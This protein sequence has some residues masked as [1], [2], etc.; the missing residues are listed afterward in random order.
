M[1]TAK[2]CAFFS[3]FKKPYMLEEHEGKYNLRVLLPNYTSATTAKRLGKNYLKESKATCADMY[4][5]QVST[6]NGRGD[7]INLP[8]GAQAPKVIFA[9]LFDPE[10]A[11]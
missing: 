2:L 3:R 9:E 10:V 11:Q 4:P 7:I 6:R 5:K 1:K 8:F